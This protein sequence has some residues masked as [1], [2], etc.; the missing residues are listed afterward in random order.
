MTQLLRVLAS[1]A[2]DLGS[3][4]KTLMVSHSSLQL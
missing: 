1:L 3:V 4:P 2:K